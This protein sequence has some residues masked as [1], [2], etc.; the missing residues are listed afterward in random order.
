MRL[1]K[2]FVLYIRGLT[3]LELPKDR[4]QHFIS[5][6]GAGVTIYT[7]LDYT[8]RLRP[9]RVPFFRLKVYKEGSE[10]TLWWGKL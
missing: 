1:A 7:G 6:G 9:K 2:S 3:N 5:Q 4:P 8:G 10:F